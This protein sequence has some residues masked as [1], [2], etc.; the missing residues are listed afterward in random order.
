MLVYN[1]LKCFDFWCRKT[2]PQHAAYTVSARACARSRRAS[3]HIILSL[4]HYVLDCCWKDWSNGGLINSSF[5]LINIINQ[6]KMQ[7]LYWCHPLSC[8]SFHRS[9]G[10][11]LFIQ[12]RDFKD[13]VFPHR[14]TRVFKSFHCCL[15]TV[16]PSMHP[17]IFVLARHHFAFV[18]VA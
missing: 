11:L 2:P 17:G 10:T 3:A 16:L 18:L 1:L 7:R 8:D 15:A 6:A 9:I 13:S 4:F 14:S 12:F 5:W